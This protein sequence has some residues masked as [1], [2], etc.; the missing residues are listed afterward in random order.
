MNKALKPEDIPAVEWDGE[1]RREAFQP[2]PALHL[3]WARRLSSYARAA[4]YMALSKKS[5][6]GADFLRSLCSP[7]P[8]PGVI[9]TARRNVL[10]RHATQLSQDTSETVEL[11]DVEAGRVRRPRVL[12]QF[13]GSGTIPL[14]ALRLGCEA[15]AGDLNPVAYLIQL[16]GLHYPQRFGEATSAAV[17]SASDGTWAGLGQEARVWGQW[18]QEQVSTELR[19]LYPP[20]PHPSDTGRGTTLSPQVYLWARTVQCSNPD[21]RATVPLV[22][23]PWLLKRKGRF[24]ALKPEL[25]AEARRV[26]YLVVESSGKGALGFDPNPIV[27]RGE[28]PCPLCGRRIPQDHIREEGKRGCLGTQLLAVVCRDEEGERVYLD[29][30][31]AMASVPASEDVNQRI[32]DLCEKTG[33]NA[34]DEPLAQGWMRP[35]PRYGLS[36]YSDLLTPRQLLTLMTYTKYIPRAHGQMLTQRYQAERAKAVATYLALALDKLV[37]LNSSLSTW[38]R[39]RQR[40]RPRYGRPGLWMTWDFT[41]VNP[42]AYPATYVDQIG[43][44]VSAIDERVDTGLPAQVWCASATDL[45]FDDQSFDA[46]VT[47]PPY[48]DNVTYADLSDF[49]YVWLKRSVGHLYSDEFAF[50][51]TPKAE[52]VI[53]DPERHGGNR[54]AAR[55]AYE[56][57]ME[58]ALAEA[59]RVLKAGR[60]LA[61]FT[62]SR[63]V[64]QLQ[65]FLQLARGAGL[66]LLDAKKIQP[67][68]P[69][70]RPKKSNRYALLLTFRKSE[71]KQETQEMG[72]DAEAVLRLVDRDESPLYAGLVGLIR[73]RIREDT[74]DKCIPDR[75]AG[76]LRER[77]KEYIAE[78][79]DP[80]GVLRELLGRPGVI[81]VAEE[82][83]TEEM[84]GD[85]EWMSAE[86]RVLR[87]FGWT[88]PAPP[89]D[90]TWAAVER[91]RQ[92]LARLRQA[93]DKVELRGPLIDGMSVVEKTLRDASWAWGYALLGESRDKHFRQMLKKPLDKLAMGDIVHIYCRLPYY[94]VDEAGQQFIVRAK[95][96]FNKAHPYKPSS[97]RRYLSDEIVELRNR[98][99]HNKDNYLGETSLPDMRREFVEVLQLAQEKLQEL[100]DSGALPLIVRPVRETTDMYGRRSVELRVEDGTKREIYV[101]HSP[102]LGSDYFLFP[103]RGNPRPVDPP[104]FLRSKVVGNDS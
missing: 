43:E 12:D 104:M 81:E 97:Y 30:E 65:A 7:A 86:D 20:V 103:P 90:G 63:D 27:S 89:S 62:Y 84:A 79:E 49:F 82:V 39:K 78:S 73:D 99:E 53:V 4:V 66:E 74:L 52:E 41:E 59:A 88:V 10:T 57:M 16:C 46:I 35:L 51:L 18:V 76:S 72:A 60:V 5:D 96:L 42:L 67:D 1:A 55:A 44:L 93:R 14:E 26:R 58:D 24:V 17:G 40:V 98:I 56:Q 95:K 22:R 50:A 80:R 47:D 29:G 83:H 70:L 85:R 54:E 28:T 75:Y 11:E 92:N 101:T 68:V 38:D 33:L 69:N 31:R 61:I 37:D 9:D 77:L 25:D 102:Q 36:R 2:R 34:P 45:P 91:L 94:V 19:D 71:L 87:S 15:V 64:E 48:Y 100:L 3:W 23:Q 8:D 13:S 6:Q 32:S 21:C